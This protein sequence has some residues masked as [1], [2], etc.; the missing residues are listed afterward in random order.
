[1]NNGSHFRSL[2]LW[3]DTSA[4]GEVQSATEDLNLCMWSQRWPGESLAAA[5][6]LTTNGTRR[7]RREQRGA[8][9]SPAPAQEDTAEWHRAG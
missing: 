9:A 6:H 7:V 4:L 8:G 5:A 2:G 1:M 3:G